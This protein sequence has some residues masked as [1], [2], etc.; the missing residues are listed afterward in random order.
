MSIYDRFHFSPIDESPIM[1]E[2]E[3]S[4]YP[5]FATYS[6][7]S[8]AHSPRSPSHSIYQR[9][10]PTL[11]TQISTSGSNKFCATQTYPPS[12]FYPPQHYGRNSFLNICQQ[13]RSTPPAPFQCHRER[14]Q[15]NSIGRPILR[16]N[17]LHG[18][19]FKVRR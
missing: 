9:Q 19:N 2:Y 14:F 6:S 1:N 10:I 12:R 11:T 5:S 7:S 4:T 15:V 8:I 16:T 17:L 13:T 18:H 3:F